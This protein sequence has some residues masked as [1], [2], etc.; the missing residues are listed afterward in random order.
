MSSDASCLLEVQFRNT[1]GGRV[2]WLWTTTGTAV[3]RRRLGLF[4][5]PCSFKLGVVLVV[6][7]YFM[8]KLVIIVVLLF[9]L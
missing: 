1:R 6:L 4:A 7:F 3:A 5:V 2:F 8:L 9:L